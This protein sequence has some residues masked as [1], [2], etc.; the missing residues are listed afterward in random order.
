VPAAPA[1]GNFPATFQQAAQQ[2]FNS[3]EVQLLGGYFR[4]ILKGTVGLGVGIAS[5][6]SVPVAGLVAPVL[7]AYADLPWVPKAQKVAANNLAQDLL[8]FGAVPLTNALG[9]PG[10]AAQ[11]TLYA[12]S[13]WWTQVNFAANHE[14]WSKLG[15]LIGEPVPSAL[16]GLKGAIETGQALAALRG[17]LLRTSGQVAEAG[18]TGTAATTDG[19]G[20]TRPTAP[21]APSAP[22]GAG[23][24][25]AV[26]V[27]DAGNGAVV[28]DIPEPN[29][30]IHVT[31]RAD[32]RSSDVIQADGGYLPWEPNGTTSLAM[33]VWKNEP[34]QYVGTTESLGTAEMAALIRTAQAKVDT[35]YVALVRVDKGINVNAQLQALAEGGDQF[36]AKVFQENSRQ[37][38]WAMPGGVPAEQ[39][40]GWFPFSFKTG[41]IN[42][43][44]FIVN[45]AYRP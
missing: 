31:M 25:T 36:A 34:S 15:Q 4:G 10:A 3:P 2:F 19:V 35:A 44:G 1:Q 37:K 20:A 11:G 38:E 21:A 7:S 13:S 24:L 23:G 17:K 14:Q 30:T 42:A 33:Y 5:L 22:A 45:P 12:V 16:A 39:I 18:A 41:K 8:G 43:G 9:N 26:T 32:L 40:L 28:V 6:A 29:G 27:Q